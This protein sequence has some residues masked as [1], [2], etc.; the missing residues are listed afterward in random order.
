MVR[1]RSA[2]R[3][4]GNWLGLLFNFSNAL[5]AVAFRRLLGVILLQGRLKATAK[6]LM[7]NTPI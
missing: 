5:L 6:R 7:V 3:Y 1:R 2:K 4:T